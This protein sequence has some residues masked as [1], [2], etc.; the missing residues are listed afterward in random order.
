[1]FFQ[2][3]TFTIAKDASRPDEN[4][5]AVAFDADRGIAAI[6]DGASSTLFAARWAAALAKAAVADPPTIE[7][8]DSLAGWLSRLRDEWRRIMWLPVMWSSS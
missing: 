2:H 8:L 6:A 5:D 1:M 3:R 7:D 4:Q